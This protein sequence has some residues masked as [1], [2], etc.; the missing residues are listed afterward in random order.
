[1]RILIVSPVLP[2]PPIGG[3]HQRLYHMLEAMADAHQ[4]TLVAFTY[5]ETVSHPPFPVEV[6][7][8]P[9]RLP[10]LYEDMSSSNPSV[11]ARAHADLSAHDMPPF[12]V[13][14]FESAEMDNAIRTVLLDGFDLAVVVTTQMGRFL[15]ALPDN[16]PVLLD[17]WNVETLVTRRTADRE[18]GGDTQQRSGAHAAFRKETGGNVLNLH[19]CIGSRGGSREANDRG[20]E[21][22]GPVKR[23]G[24][25]LLRAPRSRRFDV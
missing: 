25:G 12:F 3:G 8:V 24:H 2:F 21:C 13:S 23:C 10:R 20:R 6:H 1:M 5:G 15:D 11:S 4:L 19:H 18:R 17:F 16:L 7:T 14:Y 22:R 9:W